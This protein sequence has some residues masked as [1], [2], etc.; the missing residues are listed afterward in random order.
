MDK[1]ENV[2]DAVPN[3]SKAVE[4]DEEMG[5]TEDR[6]S[7]NGENGEVEATDAAR[8]K[9]DGLGVKLSGVRGTGSGGRILVKDVKRAAERPASST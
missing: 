9:A 1:P 2:T 5:K 6:E 4:S 8:R 3:G 7:E